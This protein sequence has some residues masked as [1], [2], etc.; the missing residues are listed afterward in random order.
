MI[1][2]VRLLVAGAASLLLVGGLAAIAAGFRLEG[3]YVAGLGVA[4]LVVVL[5]ERQRYGAGDGERRPN[6]ERHRPTEE[7]FM[8]PSSGQRTRV[9]I[10]P[11]TGERSYRPD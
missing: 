7:V 8:D 1:H 11:V 9:W 10:D 2:V 6:A 5:L 3:L 4:G